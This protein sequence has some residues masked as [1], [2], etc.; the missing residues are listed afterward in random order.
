MTEE[1]YR[2]W[3]QFSLNVRRSR[4]VVASKPGV[5]ANGRL[6]VASV[7][8][9]TH[10]QVSQGDV[11]VYMNCGNGLAAAVGASSIGAGSVL[12]SDRNVVSV[13]AAQR[14]L[15]ANGV[16]PAEV[17]L[18]HGSRGFP[19]ELIADVVAIRIPHEKLS[20]LQL[21][22]D[23]HRLLRPGGRCYLAGATNE[24]IKAA[25]KLLNRIFGSTSV[26]EYDSGHRIVVAE[27][28]SESAIDVTAIDNG[29][30]DGDTFRELDVTL[31]GNRLK[32]YSRPGV[33]S[34][35][36]LDEATDIL[37]GTIDIP[38]GASTLDLGCGSGTLGITAARLSGGGRVVM[39]DADAEA[40]RSATK[41][42][43]AAGID[44]YQVIPSDVA[45]A[46]L[47]ERFDVVV[48]NPPFH[49]GKQTELSIPTQFIDDA[50][51]VLEPG[52][53]LFLVANRTLPYEVP[54]KH[55]F[56]DVETLHDGRR[57]K[58]LSATR[59]RVT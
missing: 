24:G 25:A 13:E 45:G 43:E 26:L 22:F 38:L 19:A 12:L 55:R 48:T 23:A 31:R 10:V 14:T 47:D 59:S 4:Y 57:F 29:Y 30:L 7:M 36:H 32:L 3:S 39:V 1:S 15:A 6:D 18:A 20:L 52:G 35:D 11:A 46:V 44:D 51:Q 34:W 17:M 8:L 2:K 53:R 56:G 40:V 28:I 37:A 41:S 58:V 42:A 5:F 21:L 50:W 49:V 9:A 54:I 27:K 33:F 16:T